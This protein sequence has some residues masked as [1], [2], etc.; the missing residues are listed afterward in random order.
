MPRMN[1]EQDLGK[2]KSPVTSQLGPLLRQ[3][4][5][6]LGKS[7]KEVA[8]AAGIAPVT[9]HRLETGKASCFGDTYERVALALGANYDHVVRE[10][11]RR[12]RLPG[13]DP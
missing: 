7:L 6:M 12:I 4:R 9:L 8:K 5:L 2:E 10:A 11:R 3:I 1:P 13:V